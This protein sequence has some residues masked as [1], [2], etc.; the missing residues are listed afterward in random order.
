[1]DEVTVPGVPIRDVEIAGELRDGAMTLDHVEGTGVTGGR[2]TGNLSLAPQGD[3]YRVH[4]EA[5]VEDARLVLSKDAEPQASAPSLDVDY[6]VDGVGQSLREMAASASGRV[7]VVMGA[8]RVPNA[9]C[10]SHVVRPSWRAP[11]GCPQPVPEV[12]PVH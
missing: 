2:V 4:A 10:R 12:V 11:P 1:M 9:H 6:E 8:G 3:G 5:R 7:L